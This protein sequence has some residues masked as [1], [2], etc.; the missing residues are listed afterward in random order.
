MKRVVILGAGVGGLAAAWWLGRAG[1]EVTVVEQAPDLRSD[2]YMVGLSGAGYHAADRMGLIPALRP[3]SREIG[4]NVFRDRKGRELLRLRY[5]DLL[6]GI[7]WLTLARTDLVGVLREA[8]EGLATLRFGTTLQSLTQEKGRV[9][10]TLGDG[11]ALE[12]ELLIGADGARSMLRR[13]LFGEDGAAA[14]PLGYRA[15]AFQGPDRL[16][17][18]EDFLSYAEP[19]RMA[20]TYTLDEGRLATLYI[21]RSDETGFVPPA[22]RRDVLRAAFEGAH[23]HALQWIDDLPPGEP[24]Y[25]DALTMID[26]PAWSQGRALLLGDAAHCLTLVSG[27]GAGMALTS[28]RILAEELGRDDDVPVALARHETRLRPAI[29][30]LQEHSRKSASWFVPA[31]PLAFHL[32]NT[33]MRWTPRPLLG[34]RLIKAI[35]SEQLLALE[36]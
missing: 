21:W 32:R 27:Q 14:Q 10:V 9:Q 6:R 15:A 2:G 30:R 23:P 34:R 18:G 24:V 35:R 7:D 33:V 19:G 17:L 8:V 12:A 22:A 31:T 26:L 29:R 13:R 3:R 5:R 11:T 28:A 4:E 20:E 16:G 36:R 25:L 1:W